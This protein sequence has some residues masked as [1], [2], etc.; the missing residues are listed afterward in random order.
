MKWSKFFFEVLGLITNSGRHREVK[1]ITERV[2][3]YEDAC[4]VLGDQHPLV[5]QCRRLI[6]IGE[7]S[8][9]K[10]LLAYAKLRVITTALNEGW[11]YGESKE[12]SEGVMGSRYFPIYSTASFEDKYLKELDTTFVRKC[13]YDLKL[14]LKS[15]YLAEYVS[16]QF[17]SLLSDYI[18]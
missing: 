9:T 8:I 15:K 17:R 4:R 6:A 18:L 11:H 5:S 10:D 2:K 14:S 13:N 16:T 3:T 1:P 7:S 12:N